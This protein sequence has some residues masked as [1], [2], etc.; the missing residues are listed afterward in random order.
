MEIDNPQ[1]A[2]WDSATA[3]TT[4]NN[5]NTAKS[6]PF[7]DEVER[8]VQSAEGREL[9]A[10]AIG[11]GNGADG[12]NN[13]NSNSSMGSPPARLTG[14]GSPGGP[15]TAVEIAR[16][17]VLCAS[18]EQQSQS[19]SQPSSHNGRNSHHPRPQTDAE[20]AHAVHVPGAP[21]SDDGLDDEEAC[22]TL[23]GWAG[24]DGD[25]LAQLIPMLERHVR[26]AASVDLIGEARAVCEH[27]GGGAAGG[28][29]RKRGGSK[30]QKKNKKKNKMGGT[31]TS[32]SGE[33]DDD[34]DDEVE[35]NNN[36]HDGVGVLGQVAH[37][38]DHTIYAVGTKIRKPFD[39]KAYDGEV[40]SYDA[41]AGYYKVQYEDG[42]EEEMDARQI[43]TLLVGQ[44]RVVAVGGGGAANAGTGAGAGRK[45]AT[46]SEVSW[47]GVSCI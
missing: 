11:G 26:S 16:L 46:V 25:V 15:L 12:N 30:M 2:G 4:A 39:G 42:D 22:P 43:Q 45:A 7:A 24:V 35:D 1:M 14:A 34:D 41:R 44:P 5:H 47:L 20:S 31:S 37:G 28:G 17:S 6:N 19:Q 9:S 36:G 21:A 18:L 32:S 27:G 40:V 33:D 10:A 13:S 23:A 29:A 3:T 38:A 8:I